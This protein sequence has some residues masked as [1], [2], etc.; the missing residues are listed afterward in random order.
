LYVVAI[1][2]SNVF[3]TRFTIMSGHEFF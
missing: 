3:V 1:L 2:L